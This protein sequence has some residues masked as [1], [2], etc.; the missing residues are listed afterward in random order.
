M[1]IDNVSLHG[2]LPLLK[3]GRA[4]RNAAGHPSGYLLES[5]GDRVAVVSSNEVSETSC[6]VSATEANGDTVSMPPQFAE[7]VEKCPN[8]PIQLKL[9]AKRADLSIGGTKAKLQLMSGDSYP[10]LVLG[11]VE[12]SWK[13]H[14]SSLKKALHETI[15]F[16]PSSD[17]RHCLNGVL[18]VVKTGSLVC[19]ASNGQMMAVS[20]SAATIEVAD[21]VER[22]LPVLAV[23]QLLK[24]LDYAPEV[25]I[26]VAENAMLFKCATA[27]LKIKPIQERFPN[28]KRIM[29]IRPANTVLMRQ[30][31]FQSA[32]S[33]VGVFANQKF[34]VGTFDITAA[35]MQI[36]SSTKEFG[37]SAD[38]VPLIEPGPIPSKKFYGNLDFMKLAAGTID[39]ENIRLSYAE[40]DLSSVWFRK[41]NADDCVVIVTPCKP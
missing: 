31:D 9:T 7:I 27:E 32:L 25:D 2:F 35:G 10:R 37:E 19:V 24:I 39:T 18:L 33:R 28:W 16:A 12:H 30:V 5:L 11:K 23:R 15:Q 20:T 34:P 14:S 1:Q 38:V 26:V 29:S 41:G 40:E 8:V 36:A 13:I 3:S 4:A 6:F 22:L 21:A 17:P